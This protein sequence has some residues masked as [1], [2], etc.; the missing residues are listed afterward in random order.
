MTTTIR[1]TRTRAIPAIPRDLWMVSQPFLFFMNLAVKAPEST[2]IK[3][4]E[5]RAK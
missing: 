3:P 2:R 1:P 4:E 5:M